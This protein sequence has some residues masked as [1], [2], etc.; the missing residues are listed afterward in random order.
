VLAVPVRLSVVRADSQ[1]PGGIFCKTL[2]MLSN[3]F[4]DFTESSG[5]ASPGRCRAFPRC[6]VDR[7]ITQSAFLAAEITLSPLQPPR[8]RALP[9]R[10]AG[11]TRSAARLKKPGRGERPFT[12]GY[13]SWTRQHSD[14]RRRRKG[15]RGLATSV[16]LPWRTTGTRLSAADIH[17]PASLDICTHLALKERPV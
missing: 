16:W 7:S 1:R 17:S 9:Q 14:G 11:R 6:G 13:P 2:L 5:I 15:P 10:M 4:G 8:P 3:P 12:P